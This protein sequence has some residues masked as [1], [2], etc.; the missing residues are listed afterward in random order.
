LIL[1]EA[2]LKKKKKQV[3]TLLRVVEEKMDFE[4]IKGDRKRGEGKMVERPE[5]WTIVMTG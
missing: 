2:Q 3:Q 1:Y 5:Q 4:G